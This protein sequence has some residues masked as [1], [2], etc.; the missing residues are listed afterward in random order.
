V[1]EGHLARSIA[2]INVVLVGDSDMLIDRFWMQAQD[3]LGQRMV[4]PT[5]NNGDFLVNVLDNLTGSSD[6]ISLRGRGFS[7]R[8]FELVEDLRRNAELKFRETEQELQQKIEELQRQ[9]GQIQS[10][11]VK[12]SGAILTEEQRESI[13][14]FRSQMLETR[15]QLR[16]VQLALRQDIESL[17]TTLKLVNIWAVPVVVMVIALMMAVVRRQRHRRHVRARD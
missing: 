16:Q 1:P 17:D 14:T 15:A 12:E 10:Q 9:M 8:P 13:N 5:S 3:F 11:G 4:Q 7:V 6:L 2:P